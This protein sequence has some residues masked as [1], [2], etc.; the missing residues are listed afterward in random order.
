M[1]ALAEANCLFERVFTFQKSNSWCLP[2]EKAWTVDEAQW[3]V[4]AL[5]QL[6][7]ELNLTKSLL[8]CMEPV[9]WRRHTAWTNR[10]GYVLAQVRRAANPTLLTQ[11]WCKF[12]EILHEFGVAEAEPLRSFHLC[13]APGAFISALQHYLEE[14]AVNWCWYATT[15]NPYYEGNSTKSTVT[16]DRLIF[17][18]LGHWYFGR[19]QTGDVLSPSFCIDDFMKD[20]ELF[21]LVTADGSVDCQDDPAEQEAT[22][23]PLHCA[24]VAMALKLLAKGGNLVLKMFTFFQSCSA[25]LLFILNCIFEE[26]HVKKPTCSKPGNSEVYVV[27]LKLRQN[28]PDVLSDMLVNGSF[29][30]PLRYLPRDYFAQ[31]YNCARYFKQLQ[32]YT[33]QENVHW[34]SMS[35]NTQLSV[36]LKQV[37]NVVAALYMERYPCKP[38]SKP[39]HGVTR[40]QGVVAD[41]RG[42]NVVSFVER[43]TNKHWWKDN[44]GAIIKQLS[45]FERQEQLDTAFAHKEYDRVVPKDSWIVRGRPYENV[46]ISKFCSQPLLDLALMLGYSSEVSMQSACSVSRG[47]PE[48][49]EMDLTKIVLRLRHSEQPYP[50]A[51]RLPETLSRLSAGIIFL[52]SSA[53]ETTSVECPGWLKTPL[54]IF[55]KPRPGR[56]ATVASHFEQAEAVEGDEKQVLLEVVP[57][58]YMCQCQDFADFLVSI[59][60]T[61]LYRW[62]SGILTQTSPSKC[63][64]DGTKYRN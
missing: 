45:Q 11:A 49:M 58:E 60:D 59:N 51:L 23:A 17:N 42:W 12:Y 29:R 38:A 14:R 8:N 64:K 44:V 2:S 41:F 10:A 22:V 15:L 61:L 33:I 16:D 21:D 13:E 63:D 56:V 25:C 50:L 47:G 9:E 48:S 57:L 53:F 39:L 62:S 4:P 36:Y 3:E 19:D 18:T 7:A 32:E 40:T 27:C 5:Q 37:K 24:E 54:W 30:F 35:K 46:R 1:S 6:K 28:V 34:F 52:L 43:S 31:L 26:V 55:D 20:Q